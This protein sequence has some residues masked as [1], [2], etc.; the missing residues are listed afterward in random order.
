MGEK[1]VMKALL[2]TVVVALGLVACNS[3]KAK[4]VAGL[5]TPPV[6]ASSFGAIVDESGH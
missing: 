4:P 5:P 2:V 3:E 1:G 6:T